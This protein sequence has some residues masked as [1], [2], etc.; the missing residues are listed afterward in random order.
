MVVALKRMGPTVR[1]IDRDG[2][3]NEK[4]IGYLRS[5]LVIATKRF[6]ATTSTDPEFASLLDSKDWGG[7]YDHGS[8]T[9]KRW[10]TLKHCLFENLDCSR[11]LYFY[12]FHLA[13]EKAVDA[14]RSSRLAAGDQIGSD[15]QNRLL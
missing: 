13:G 12:F 6:L 4:S 5:R 15:H 10:I 8:W 14:T 3:N 7:G 2:E 9:D 11:K 1:R